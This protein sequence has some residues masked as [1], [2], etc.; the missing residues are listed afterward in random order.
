MLMHNFEAGSGS[1]D[2]VMKMLMPLGDS[3][4]EISYSD[5]RE[6]AQHR[7]KI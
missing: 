1:S 3:L 4:V 7:N 2:G 6:K 5:Q